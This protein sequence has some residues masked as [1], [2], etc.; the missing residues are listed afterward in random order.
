MI[1][2]HWPGETKNKMALWVNIQLQGMI[3]RNYFASYRDSISKGND[4]LFLEGNPLGHWWLSE[5]FASQ[6]SV[7]FGPSAVRFVVQDHI[8]SVLP[9]KAPQGRECRVR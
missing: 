7:E 9:D 4:F 2:E 3:P 8:S 5:W 6:S 1:V